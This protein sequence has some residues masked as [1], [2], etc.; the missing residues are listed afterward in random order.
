MKRLILTITILLIPTT[1]VSELSLTIGVGNYLCLEYI[2]VINNADIIS[3]VQF[4]AWAN[5]FISGVNSVTNIKR[6]G[7]GVDANTI[8][9]WLINHCEQNSQ[10]PFI[11]ASLK[12]FK[13]LENELTQ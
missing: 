9:Q 8:E 4:N 11:D 5:G 6:F 1:A 10:E 2:N 7:V 13:E 3:K 12:L